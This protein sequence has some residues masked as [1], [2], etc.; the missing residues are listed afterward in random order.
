MN[1][2]YKILIPILIFTF[3]F[4]KKIKNL[5]ENMINEIVIKQE[6]IDNIN[7]LSNFIDT[8]SRPNAIIN[9]KLKINSLNILPDETSQKKAALIIG[10]QDNWSIQTTQN[11]QDKPQL[12]N[13]LEMIY[14]T[15]ANNQQLQ[16]F[17]RP[18]FNNFKFSGFKLDFTEK[19][20]Y[21]FFRISDNQLKL[22][23][24][25]RFNNWNYSLDF[26]YLMLRE[27]ND[28]FILQLG[29]FKINN[30]NV[31]VLGFEPNFSEEPYNRKQ[32]MKDFLG[33]GILGINKL[34]IS[35]IKIDS[36]G[37][38]SIIFNK[39]SE[40]KNEINKRITGTKVINV[41]EGENFTLDENQKIKYVSQIN[42]KK[43][44]LKDL[45]VGTH[46]CNLQKFDNQDPHPY[47]FKKCVI[48]NTEI[49]PFTYIP[50]PIP[51]TNISVPDPVPTP[52]IPSTIS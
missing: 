32:E 41:S 30:L 24:I 6:Y 9:K 49:T 50:N 8:I 36:N 17:Y 48:Y 15:P 20:F 34:D 29:I 1:F 40:F 47:F 28:Q 7:N 14:S 16:E 52:K 27:N 2:D 19:S 12:N 37:V 45:E 38:L 21:D 10:D 46:T 3:L 18:I 26:K 44:V 25:L 4:Y 51:S 33:E 43:F 23:Y 31:Y 35:E 39:K 42:P 5:R 13:T 22:F 11:N